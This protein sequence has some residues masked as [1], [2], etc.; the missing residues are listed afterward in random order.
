MNSLKNSAAFQ[1]MT[2]PLCCFNFE[3]VKMIGAYGKNFFKLT[4]HVPSSKIFDLNHLIIFK[5]IP[6][7]L[8]QFGPWCETYGFVD[9]FFASWELD[10]SA[11][12]AKILLIGGY[13]S[14]T[15]M[16]GMH[17]FGIPGRVV[18]PLPSSFYFL[19]WPPYVLHSHNLSGWAT[20][21]GH[22]QFGTSLPSIPSYIRGLT[23]Q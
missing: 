14:L 11:T 6:L 16:I 22:L 9:I 21:P 5:L 2:M 3:M 15:I 23:H 18:S 7:F 12:G 13:L 4:T 19:F 17:T 10:A 8:A 1:S 20:L